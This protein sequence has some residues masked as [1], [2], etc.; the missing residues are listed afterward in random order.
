MRNTPGLA[1]IAALACAGPANAAAPANSIQAMFAVLNRCMASVRIAPGTDVTVQFM[2]NRR[3][4]LIGKP[5]IT[6]AQWAGDEDQRKAS[7]ASIAQGFDRCLPLS[8]SDALGGAIAGRLIAYR[9][10]GPRQGEY[11]S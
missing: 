4:G 8:I 9:F 2:L 10:H 1:I 11:K 7:A 3:G 6:H 5:R